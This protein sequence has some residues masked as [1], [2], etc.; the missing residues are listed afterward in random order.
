M[1]SPS[2]LTRQAVAATLHCLTGCAIGEIA[3]M[4]V[5]AALNLSNA[6]SVVLSIALAFTFGYAL[7]MRPVLKA[8][9]S[10]RRAL[11]V[12][13][14]SDTVSI[15]TMEICDNLFILLVPGAISAGLNAWLF[16][17]SLLVSLAVAFVVTV[18]VNR[19][20]IARGLGHAAMHQFH[21]H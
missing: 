1:N 7:S 5:S 14:A 11:R 21:D 10:F 16:W 19:F 2:K 13:F 3:G 15:T 9:L 4:V 6:V 18:P 8:G 20:L 17:W 12:A